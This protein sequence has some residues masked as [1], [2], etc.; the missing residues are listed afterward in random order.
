M[1]L[2]TTVIKRDHRAVETEYKKFQS[3]KSA[4]EKRRI[5]HK[6]FESLDAHAKMEE[7][8]YYPAVVR[9]A[10]AK[11][12][13]MIEEARI[14][15][16]EMKEMIRRFMRE[17]GGPGFG[18]KVGELLAG[19]MHHVKEEEKE[20]MPEV[21]RSMKKE[22]LEELGEKMDKVSPT[23]GQTMGKQLVDRVRANAKQM[24]S[25]MAG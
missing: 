2:P 7:R 3:A 21:D 15:H 12:R 11:A 1:S 6:I 10:S 13:K 5:A 24:T 22:K 25:K 19:V 4:P 18:M 23:R 8:F 20:L 14:E 16:A 17:K 9:D